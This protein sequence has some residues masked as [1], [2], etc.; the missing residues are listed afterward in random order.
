MPSNRAVI[1]DYEAAQH[2]T[3]LLPSFSAAFYT[4]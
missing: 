4:Y 3:P 1:D 2:L